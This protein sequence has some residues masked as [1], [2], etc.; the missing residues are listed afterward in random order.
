M[1]SRLGDQRWRDESAADPFT[2]DGKRVVRDGDLPVRD[3]TLTEMND[4]PPSTESPVTEEAVQEVAQAVDGNASANNQDTEDDEK[5]DVSSAS[6]SVEGESRVEVR[7]P[8]TQVLELFNA[9][10]EMV[11]PHPQ[12]VRPTPVA[13]VAAGVRCP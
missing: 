8:E 4:V 12:P 3:R 10:L 5:T 11:A 6:S 1:Y 13:P 2:E 7:L 9:A